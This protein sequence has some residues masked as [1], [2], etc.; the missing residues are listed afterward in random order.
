VPG[1]WHF[2]LELR[3]AALFADGR[4]DAAGARQP[5]FAVS[6][7]GAR[8]AASYL[9]A[10]TTL[11]AEVGLAQRLSV[12]T[13]FGLLDA[14]DQPLAGVGARRAVG[15]SDLMLGGKLL[16]FDDEVTAALK[17]ALTAPTGSATGALP[18]G[19]GDLRT[20]FMLLV[21]RAFFRPNIY[22]S[23]EVG[24]RLRGAAVVADPEQPGQRVLAQYAHEI[25]YAAQAGYTVHPDRRGARAVGL[26]LKL[27]GSYALAP[28]VE[29]GLGV[30]N[31]IAGSYL[32][33]GPQLLWSPRGGV[34]LTVDGHYFVAGRSMP[35]FGEVAVAVGVSR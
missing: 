14:V 19:P 5:I 25:R 32:K 33:L 24:V 16:L 18:L 11:Y 30:L 22:L 3:Q 7:G 13:M 31:P 8:V 6:D 2:Y 1:R 34:S 26:A 21:G 4:Y 17:V 27:E 9:Q 29:D 10:F 12:L 23:G 15:V 35:A 28:A 20:D